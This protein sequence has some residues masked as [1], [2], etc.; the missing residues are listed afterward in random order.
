MSAAASLRVLALS[1]GVGGARMAAGLQAVL[2]PGALTVLVNTADDFVHLGL[3]ISPDLDTVLYTLAGLHDREQGWGL[4]GE[5]WRAM[6][7]LA[8]LGGPTWFRLGDRDLATH[9]YRTA[10]LQ[11]GASLASVSAELGQRLGLATRLLPMCD[12]PVRTVLQT[13]QGR[14]DFQN[15]FVRERCRPIVESV[16]FAGLEASRPAAGFAPALAES[17]M[18][19]IGP[20]NPFVSVEPILRV[21]GLAAALEAS[22]LSIVAVSPIIGGRAI[23]GPAAAMLEGF[24]FEVS[25]VGIARWYEQSHPGLIDVWIVDD[26][27]RMLK[28]R[29]EAL[30]LVVVVADTHIHE[31]G[32][33]AALARLALRSA[34]ARARKRRS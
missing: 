10:R 8:A 13:D 34:R 6:G 17:E 14:L 21:P 9:L 24:G 20:S 18:V 25:P 12:E 11:Q 4:A 5:T 28:P 27:D 2:S 32:N 33:A 26:T 23:K 3:S 19:V 30:G 31:E 15:W 16:T 29:I 7:A 22:G 1:G